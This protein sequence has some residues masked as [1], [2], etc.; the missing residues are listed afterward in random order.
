MFL[1]KNYFLYLTTI[2]LLTLL[3]GF[4]CKEKSDVVGEDD[5]TGIISLSGQIINNISGIPIEEA[6]IVI[7][8]TG[9]TITL[10]SDS[11]RSEEHT[12]EL[13]SRENLVC[14]LLLDEKK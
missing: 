1:S 6:T 11:Q 7:T 4:G 10:K 8:G 13:Q 14:R 12:S 9:E 5:E 2:L 3:I